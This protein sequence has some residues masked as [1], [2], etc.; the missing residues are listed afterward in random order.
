MPSD[1]VPRAA[2]YALL[3]LATVLLAVWG[4]FLV[5]LRVGGRPVPLGLLLALAPVALCRVGGDLLGRRSAALVPGALWLLT[6]LT[7][8]SQRREGDLV[9]TGGLLGLAFVA[10][11]TLSAAA[12]V[13]AWRPAAASAAAHDVVARSSEGRPHG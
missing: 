8:G 6:A 11:G 12:A 4:A 9:V 5:P 7:L 1:R 13:G 2:A 10:I 3:L